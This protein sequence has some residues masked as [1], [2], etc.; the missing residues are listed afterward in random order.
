M[1]NMKSFKSTCYLIPFLCEWEADRVS[2]ENFIMNNEHHTK[3]H[4][5]LFAI[6]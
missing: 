6:Y 5:T 2:K 3:Q 1:S 4:I